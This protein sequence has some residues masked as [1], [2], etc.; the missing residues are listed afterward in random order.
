[1]TKTP[2]TYTPVTM[3]H[4]AFIGSFGMALTFCTALFLLPAAVFLV[5]AAAAPVLIFGAGVGIV[6]LALKK[7][8]KGRLIYRSRPVWRAAKNAIR[9]FARTAS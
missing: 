1:M 9:P 3:K 5:V 6:Y 4:P 2:T 8:P 7:T